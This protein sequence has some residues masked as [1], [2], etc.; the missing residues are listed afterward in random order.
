VQR[1]LIVDP[2]AAAGEEVLAPRA[3]GMTREAR[4]R[5]SV[6]AAE[7]MLRMLAGE[8]PRNLVNPQARRV[9]A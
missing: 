1:V 7:E 3:A 5:M 9:N 8:P 2:I 4:A 6:A